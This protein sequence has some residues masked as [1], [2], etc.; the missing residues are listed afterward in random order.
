M[1]STF[2]LSGEDGAGVALII[3]VHRAQPRPEFR[4]ANLLV[5]RWIK[6]T[7][8]TRSDLIEKSP[9]R[10]TAGRETR[11]ISPAAGDL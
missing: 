11:S 7:A 9:G 1:V 4:S 10:D 8:E 5:L 3:D 2:F 6:Q